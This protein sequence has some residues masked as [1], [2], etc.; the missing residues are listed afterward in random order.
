[1]P[2]T[3]LINDQEFVYVILRKKIK[4]LY[5]RVKSDGKIYISCN[6]LVS[7]KHLRNLLQENADA[8]I[9]MANATQRKKEQVLC[10]L[11]NP[12][13][14]VITDEEPQLDGDIIYGPNKQACMN[15]LYSL[16]PAIFKGR[17][18]R[19]QEQFNNLPDFNLKV[20]KMSSKWGVCNKKSMTVTLN[21]ELITKDV[22]LIDYVII[23]ELCHFKHMDHSKAYWSYVATFYPYYKQ[24]RKELK[25]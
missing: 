23:H 2:K 19:L 8:I 16:A 7:E 13:T 21:S 15:Y 10:Y 9:K 22:H 25:Y 11:G 14:F 1:M 24:A 5:F 12:L 4:H 20:R 17:L 18:N 3:I 6:A